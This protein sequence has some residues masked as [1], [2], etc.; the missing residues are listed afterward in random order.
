MTFAP[1]YLIGTNP[2][3]GVESRL[4]INSLHLAE[5]YPPHPRAALAEDL[6]GTPH[7]HLPDQVY[8]E[9]LELIGEVL[10]AALPWWCNSINLAIVAKAPSP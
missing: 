9:G 4:R 6:A 7:G 3:H 10:A 8:G 5:E 2:N 1:V